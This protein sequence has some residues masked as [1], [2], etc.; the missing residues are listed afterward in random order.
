MGQQ[1]GRPPP[2]YT[3]QRNKLQREGGKDGWKKRGMEVKRGEM[4]TWTPSREGREESVKKKSL[5]KEL[6]A[7]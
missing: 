3:H 2:L 5:E 6:A 4:G 1:E 7:W